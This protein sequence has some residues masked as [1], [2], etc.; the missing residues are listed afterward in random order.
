MNKV[1]IFGTAHLENPWI[2]GK[3]SPDKSFQEAVFSRKLAKGLAVIMQSYGFISL[4]D[5]PGLAPDGINIKAFPNN[6]E[7]Q[8]RAELNFRVNKVNELD[9]FNHYFKTVEFVKPGFLNITI[10]DE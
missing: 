4:V 3:H 7:D 2:P 5:Y 9:N 8:Q 10:S 1:V 6:W